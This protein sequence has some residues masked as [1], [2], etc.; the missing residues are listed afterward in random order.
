MAL[1]E[2]LHCPLMLGQTL[3]YHVPVNTACSSA[4]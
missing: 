1:I 3:M 4:R 2:T